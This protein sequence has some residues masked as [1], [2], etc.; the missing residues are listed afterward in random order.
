M[1]LVAAVVIWGAVAA[2]AVAVP[3]EDNAAVATEAGGRVLVKA[4]EMVVATVA[5][6]VAL[7]VET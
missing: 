5:L 1:V 6:R 2:C 3:E 7:K 4:A